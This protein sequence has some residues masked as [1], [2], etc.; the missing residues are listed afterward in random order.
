LLVA[1]LA[2]AVDLIARV[3]V[4]YYASSESLTSVWIVFSIDRASV[5]VKYGTL[6]LAP[7]ICLRNP[8]KALSALGTGVAVGML[9]ILFLFLMMSGQALFGMSVAHLLQGLNTV[10]SGMILGYATAWAYGL[11][12]LRRTCLA[13]GALSGA[14]VASIA[15]IH[16]YLADRLNAGDSY[17]EITTSLNTLSAFVLAVPL[18]VVIERHLRKQRNTPTS[19]D[20]PPPLLP[21]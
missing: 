15:T 19:G 10:L 13:V 11:R 1:A 5:A 18:G 20:R 17:D 7:C 12:A 6:G 21:R 3:I 9:I 16:W 2:V 14:I 8:W 4:R